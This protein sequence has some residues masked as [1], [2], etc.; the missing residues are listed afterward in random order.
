MRNFKDSQ[1][2][3]WS[4]DINVGSIERVLSTCE[5][6]LTKVFDSHC[7]LLQRLMDDAVLLAN[8]CWNLCQH[9]AGKEIDRDYFFQSLKGDSL[10]AAANAIVDDLI[11]FFP[12]SQ[13]RENLRALV[14]KGRQIVEIQQQEIHQRLSRT[15]LNSAIGL[16][17]SSGS[18][19]VDSPRAD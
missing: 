16:A 6:D 9:V 18:T 2:R 13:R 14:Q 19:P 8:V 5:I 3:T 11:D 15:S 7:E 1:G 4:I 12:N 17:E 10:E